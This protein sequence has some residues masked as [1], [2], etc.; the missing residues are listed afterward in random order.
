M[1]NRLAQETSPYLLQHQDN[2]VDWYPWGPEALE[3]AREEDRPILLS[4]G[5]SACHWCH[6]MERES[7]ED[8]E[9]AA[10]M[11]EHFV[12]VKVDREE[13]PDVDAIYM[14]AVQAISGHG[15]WPMTV[16][17]DPE[18]VPFYG[19]TYFPPDN[20]RGMPSFRMVMEAVIHAYATQRDEIRERAPGTRAR[21]SAIGEVEPRPDLPGTTELE[22]AVRRLLGVADRRNG[23]FGGAPKFPP[24]SSLELLLARGETE[25]VELTLDKM[26]AGGIYDQI[27]GGFARYAVDAVWLVPHFEKMLYDNALLAR[28]YLHG[29]QEL[30]HERYRRVCEETLDWM[31]REMRGPEGGF[32]SALDADSEGEEGKFYVWTP[33]E[34]EEVL[35]ADPNCIRFS[36]QQVG[37]LMQFWGV[38]EAGNFEGANI[39][40][41]TE[42]ADSEEPEGLAEARRALFEARSQRVWPGLDDKRLTSWNALAIAALADAGAVLG[43]EDYLEAAR[44]CASFLLEQLRDESGNLLRTYKDGRAHLN[45]YLEDHAFLLEALLALY[46]ASLEERWFTEARTLAETM[47]ERFGDPERGGFYST[48]SDHEELIARRKEVGDHPIPS[49]NSSAAMGLLRLEALTGDRRYGEAGAAVFALFGKPAVEHPDAFAHML[50]ALDFHLSP[51]REVALVG[52]DLSELAA[53]VREKPRPHLV[54]AGGPEGSDQPPLLAGRT[55]VD[56]KP[57]AYACENFTCQLPVTDPTE[58]RRQL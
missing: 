53:V 37:N 23:G 34:I 7:F 51:T 35:A 56:G 13:R 6:V 52:N 19:G 16:F 48:S 25:H 55:S 18:G 11:N 54:L 45:A 1:A 15:G 44:A 33:A 8:A 39:L 20:S 24:A 3:R 40:H 57:A 29:W 12:C 14:E 43:R 58:L 49:G 17:L 21:L 26:L 5:Y 2:P 38:T 27:G 28:I 42:G 22:E 10:Y 9:T 46:E 31:L 36:P 4:V 47:I 41:L 32:Y 30:G 50:R